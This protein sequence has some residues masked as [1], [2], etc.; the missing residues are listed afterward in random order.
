M[1]YI[2]LITNFE[3]GKLYV[4][5]TVNTIEYR[6]NKHIEET[7]GGNKSNSLLHRAIIKYGASS[8]GICA[9]EECADTKLNEREKY[10]IKKYDTYYTHDKG[11]NL[12]WGGEGVTK[13]SDEEILYL[14]N[15]EYRNCEIAKILGANVNTIS[16][17]IKV[18]VGEGAAQSRRADSTKIS[19]IQYDLYGNYMRDW[20]CATTAEKELGLSGGSISRCCNKQRVM[21]G[22]YLWKRSD[23]D[24]PVEELMLNYAKS[25]KCCSVDLIDDC[26]TVIRTYESGKAAELD[27]GIARGKV[28]EICNNK[29]GRKSAGGYKFQWNYKLK[30][31]IINGVK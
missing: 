21:T 31:E 28:S 22:N 9:L 13:Y 29:Y 17:R 15:Q 6:W 26:G 24:T 12:T 5:Q 3:N 20:D 1:G 14:W 25:M 8:F 4:G 16:L 11:Y 19:I 18:L 23:D 2:Y 7:Y 10:Y 30:R 27:L